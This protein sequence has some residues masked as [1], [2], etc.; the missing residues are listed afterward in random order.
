MDGLANFST[1]TLVSLAPA[2]A[3]A[4]SVD[5]AGTGWIRMDGDDDGG[6]PAMFFAPDGVVVGA[7]VAA[8]GTVTN[9]VFGRYTQDGD[10]LALRDAD[11]ASASDR[12]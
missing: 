7:D 2:A 9:K 1:P 10:V 3:S 4:D 5:L 8:S 12:S 11:G 6:R